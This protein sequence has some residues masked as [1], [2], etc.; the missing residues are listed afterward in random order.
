MTQLTFDILTMGEVTIFAKFLC[1]GEFFIF[2]NC[3][4]FS[5]FSSLTSHRSYILDLPQR[6]LQLRFIQTH[7]CN[8]GN[9]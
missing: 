3:D 2:Y 5:P 1:F 7:S 8:E 4:V 9:R 6:A